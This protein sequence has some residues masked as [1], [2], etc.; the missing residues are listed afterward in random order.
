MLKFSTGIKNLF[1]YWYFYAKLNDYIKRNKI[2]L[3]HTHHRFPE[4]VAVQTARSTGLKTVFST[5]GFVKGFQKMS[6]KSDKIIS[7]SNSASSY[8][9]DKFEIE[10]E[11]IV[12]LY[13]PVEMTDQINAGLSS[14]FKNENNISSNKKNI[15][16]VGRITRDKGYD[17]LLSAYTI[18][19]EKNKNVVLVINGQFADK[20]LRRNLSDEIIFIKPQDDIYHLYSVA[21]LVVLPSRTDSFPFVMIE[22]GSFKKPFIGGNTGGIEEFIEDGKNG[23]LVD[24]ENPKQ[25]AEKIIYLLENPEI[26]KIMGE[27]L[28]EKVKR[29]C[30]YNNYF[31]QVEKIY[32][33]LLSSR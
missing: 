27:K 29:L 16:F 25:L 6:F 32:N 19:R 5:H 1:Y 18:V 11:K 21:D 4:L 7:V 2:E 10:K 30:D 31:S 8:L 3:I 28:Y 22:A 9:T 13:N 15:L 20:K 33:S 24:P 12:T 14:K 17:T 26:G 23:L